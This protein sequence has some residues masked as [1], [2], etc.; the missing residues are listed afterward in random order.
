MNKTE[1]ING[2]TSYL[3]CTVGSSVISI[4]A[5]GTELSNYPD[6][7]KEVTDRSKVAPF[8]DKLLLSIEQIK[9][10]QT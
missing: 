7:N 3:E 5:G 2:V 4:K 10:S 9:N 6:Y 1:E 8:V